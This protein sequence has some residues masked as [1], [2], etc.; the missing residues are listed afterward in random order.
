MSDVDSFPKL[1]GGWC[2]GMGCG[3]YEPCFCKA[4]LEMKEEFQRLFQKPWNIDDVDCQRVDKL[5]RLGTEAYQNHYE[6]LEK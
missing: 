1:N 5:W 4:H 2:D 6:K 3:K